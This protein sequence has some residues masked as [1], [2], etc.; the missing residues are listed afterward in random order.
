MTGPGPGAFFDPG[1]EPW[2]RAHAAPRRALFI[3]RDGVVNVNHGYVHRAADTDFV[4]GIF[5]LVAAARAAALA[6]IVVTNQA[7]IARGLY[8]EAQFLEYTRWMH[9]EFA[10]RGAPLLA[11]YY[12]PHHPVAGIGGYGVECPCRKPAPGMLL[13]AERDLALDMPGS[14]MIG[15]QDSDIDAARA[16]GV[17]AWFKIDSGTLDS[18]GEWLGSRIRLQKEGHDAHR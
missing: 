8:T 7:G 4:P 5:D 14:L 6:P 12:C 1:C 2:L 11:T 13:R 15:D 10:R 17:R 16:A 3:D 18:A 9:G